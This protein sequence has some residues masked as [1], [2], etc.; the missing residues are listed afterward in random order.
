LG[1]HHIALLDTTGTADL[2]QEGRLT[3]IPLT[4]TRFLDCMVEVAIA[5]LL[6]E[7]GLI[8]IH[9]L[10]GDCD[11]TDACFYRGKVETV[12]HYLCNFLPQVFGCARII[13]MEDTSAVDIEEKCL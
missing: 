13:R 8:A 10:G 12:R 5:H 1:A 4:S 2:R 7:Q 11:E 6:L 3:L 9:K